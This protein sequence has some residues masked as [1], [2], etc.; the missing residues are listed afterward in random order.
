[1]KTRVPVFVLVVVH[2]ALPRCL[3]PQHLPAMEP[4][5]RVSAQ[6]HRGWEEMGQPGLEKMC[7]MLGKMHKNVQSK[8]GKAQKSCKHKLYQKN[9][10][11]KHLIHKKI[12]NFFSKFQNVRKMQ[13]NLQKWPKNILAN[14]SL[15]Q[16]HK[17]T[18]FSLH[19]WPLYAVVQIVALRIRELIICA[20]AHKKKHQP[21]IFTKPRFR[22]SYQ[23]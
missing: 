7:K 18:T 13:P 12:S 4:T 22:A 3:S 10:Q 5:E 6:F 15:V 11:K 8:R 17:H 16:F 19:A 9:I 20:N 21:P 23:A 1:M 2:C 14:Q